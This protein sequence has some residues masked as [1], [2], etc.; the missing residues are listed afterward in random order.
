MNTI[1]TAILVLGAHTSVFCN[2]PAGTEGLGPPD[3]LL[4]CEV[5]ILCCKALRNAGE[6]CD[7][8][9]DLNAASSSGGRTAFMIAAV[10]Q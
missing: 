9:Q 4:D 7:F 2:P 10:M 8:V 6:R 3:I 1:P 5:L